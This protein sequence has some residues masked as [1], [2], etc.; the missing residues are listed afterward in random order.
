MQNTNKLRLGRAVQLGIGSILVLMVIVGAVSF[1][2][3]ESVIKAQGMVTH[4]VQVEMEVSDVVR[5]MVDCETGQ[6]G[7]LL[8]G[9][10]AFLEPYHKG[11]KDI[12]TNLADLKKLLSHN[13]AQL[14]RL[15]TME[16]MIQKEL[17]RFAETIK[18]KKAGEEQQAMAMVV[19]G[20]GK[21]TMDELRA[22]EKEFQG[23][24]ADLMK[25]RQKSSD[26]SKFLANSVT[27]GGT[28]LAVAVG[29]F[30]MF[31]IARRVVRPVNEVANAIAVSSTEIA[32]AVDEQDRIAAQQA[33]S[34]NEVTTT[35][36]E[37]GA[38]AQLSADQAESYAGQAR[39]SL[40]LIEGGAGTVQQTQAGMDNMK[41]KMR[42]VAEQILRLGEQTNQISRITGLVGDLANQTNLLALN[43]AV[44]A[45]RAGEHGKGFTVVASEIR[46]LADQSKKSAEQI[47]TLVLDIQKATNAT[48]MATEEG[49]RT[50]EE[51]VGLAQKTGE[52]FNNLAVASSAAFESSQQIVLNTKQQSVAVNQVV[53]AMNSINA[54]ARQSASGVAQT[55]VGIDKLQDAARHLQ[56][57]I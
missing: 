34:V 52:V 8:T 19:S 27:G 35:M 50:V 15:K 31:F 38:S 46:K 6:R 4:T 28:L 22:R 26:Q 53:E 3:L 21:K 20:E 36:D 42:T 54:G 32:A 5:S 30:V 44:E 40:E 41:D 10:E 18:L 47:N 48:V 11:Q 57:T 9:K 13:P 25:E 29:L 24:E 14:Q 37:L 7:F 17:D 23:V 1:W 39:R 16:D 51:G 55:K 12:Q 2:I 45:A 43:A 49:T 56:A 33:A